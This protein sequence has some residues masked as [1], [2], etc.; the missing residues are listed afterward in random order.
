MSNLSD[1][2][3]KGIETQSQLPSHVAIIM[4]GNGR[5]AKKQ[6]Y[7]RLFGHRAGVR[8]VRKTVEFAARKGIKKL[9][10]FAFS[11]ENWKRPVDEV[12]GLMELFVWA[13]SKEVRKLSENNISLRIIGDVSRFSERLQNAIKKAEAD[14]SKNTGMSLVV[15]ANYGGRWDIVQAVRKISKDLKNNLLKEEDIS[16]ATL[17]SYLD[18]PMDVDLM[19]RTGGEHRI[20]NFLLWQ[21]AYSEIFISDVLWP[22]FDEHVFQMALD[23]FAGRERRFGCTSEQVQNQEFKN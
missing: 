5:W 8:S 19:I 3:T 22:D 18:E 13:L 20:S 21:L 4:D 12:S 17:T 9:T 1:A 7:V 6:G 11:S 16:E 10:L 23:Y 14:T 15:A 2:R